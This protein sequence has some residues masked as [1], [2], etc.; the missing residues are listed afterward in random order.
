MKPKETI[1]LVGI[2]EL[3][4]IIL[5]F[6]ARVPGICDIVAADS[7]TDWGVAKTNSQYPLV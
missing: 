7:N 5:E 2:G 6:L 3:G 1:L 4:G